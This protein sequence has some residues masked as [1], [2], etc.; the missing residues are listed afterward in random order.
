MSSVIS[1]KKILSTLGID[2]L[3]H[4]HSSNCI[5]RLMHS[6]VCD[7]H[8]RHGLTGGVESRPLQGWVFEA[9]WDKQKS[10]KLGLFAFDMKVCARSG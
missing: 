3:V 1:S 4:V 10:L 7:R 6:A 5:A 8:Q 2:S 9:S